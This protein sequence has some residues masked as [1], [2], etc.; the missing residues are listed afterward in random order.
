MNKSIEITEEDEII[1]RVGT[2][3]TANFEGTYSGDLIEGAIY[4]TYELRLNQQ[5]LIA[6]AQW[7]LEKAKDR[8]AEKP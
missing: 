3:P 4:E 8:A 5:Q 7:L 2:T 1:C 6:L